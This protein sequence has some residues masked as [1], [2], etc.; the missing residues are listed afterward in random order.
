[1]TQ[2]RA[3]VPPG[4]ADGKGLAEMVSQAFGLL[5]VPV[6]QPD[7]ATAITPLPGQRRD[8]AAFYRSE[9]KCW[10]EFVNREFDV[11]AHSA[12]EL[13]VER[14]TLRLLEIRLIS[15]R[16]LGASIEKDAEK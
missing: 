6:D 11:A 12:L 8:D 16:W 7:S 15:L 14:S 1:M 3:N 13:L 2:M 5:G 10:R 4:L 9:A